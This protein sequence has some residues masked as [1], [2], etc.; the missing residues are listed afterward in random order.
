VVADPD[1]VAVGESDAGANPLASHVDSVGRAQVRDHE[2]GA[3][4]DDDGVVAADVGVV[5]NDVVVDEASDPG[6]RRQQGYSWPDASRK[7]ATADAA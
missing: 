2:A 7:R 5:E 4:V 3:G 1:A 6:G